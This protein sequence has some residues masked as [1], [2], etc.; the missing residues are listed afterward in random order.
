MKSLAKV[1]ILTIFVCLITIATARP[2]TDSPE[3]RAQSLFARFVELSYAFDPAVADLYADDAHIVSIR[4]Y[5]DGPERKFE[6]KGA[7][8]KLLIR[9]AIPTAKERGDVSTFSDI[10]YQRE[11]AR[12]CVRA[13]R[14]SVLKQYSNPYALLI[15]PNASRQ[16]L[17]EAWS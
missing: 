4:K 14:Y 12:V 2:A 9:K 1:V 16:W 15:G 13:T 5:P 8:Y 17:I 7:E 11:G 3:H 6:M 10:S